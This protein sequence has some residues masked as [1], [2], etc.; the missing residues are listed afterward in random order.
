MYLTALRETCITGRVFDRMMG[1]WMQGTWF[2][3][4]GFILFN[5]NPS[6]EKWNEEDPETLMSATLC[7]SLHII[8]CLVGKYICSTCVLD[9]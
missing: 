4:I 9:L 7:F 3:Q 2:W 1:F 6:V 8:G 5:P